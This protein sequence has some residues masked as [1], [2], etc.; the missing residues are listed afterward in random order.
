MCL[1]GKEFVCVCVCV[2]F[3]SVLKRGHSGEKCHG[4]EVGLGREI[5][6]GH[7]HSEPLPYLFILYPANLI[8]L[9]LC[10]LGSVYFSSLGT[11]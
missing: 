7:C 6:G 10:L 8:N 5:E 11:N 2:T 3:L 9:F 1:H 4:P